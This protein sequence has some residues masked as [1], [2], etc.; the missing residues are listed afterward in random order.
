M[1]IPIPGGTDVGIGSAIIN[2]IIP[3][4]FDMGPSIFPAT[5]VN[6]FRD[7]ETPCRKSL[8][9]STPFAMSEVLSHSEGESF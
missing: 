1:V 4:S 7:P 6:L 8:V 9:C 3:S 2:L 5:C